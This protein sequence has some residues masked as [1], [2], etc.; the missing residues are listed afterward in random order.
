M[1]TWDDWFAYLHGLVDGGTRGALPDI[2]DFFREA[3]RCR[4]ELGLAVRDPRARILDEL[5]TAALS[6]VYVD[7][8][9]AE[10]HR[11]TAA[12]LYSGSKEGSCARRPVS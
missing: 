5:W 8:L 1:K 12:L 2:S 9:A 3:Q 6:L 11:G 10:M 7:L 4:A